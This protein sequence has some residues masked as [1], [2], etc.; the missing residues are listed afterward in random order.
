MPAI[1]G[2]GRGH[3]LLLHFEGILAHSF[4]LKNKII[5]L[6]KTLAGT[7]C[8][9]CFWHFNQAAGFNVIHIS[10]NWDVAGH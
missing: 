7:A 3:G 2:F 6:A 4:N 10:V 1:E 8:G 5:C 9:R